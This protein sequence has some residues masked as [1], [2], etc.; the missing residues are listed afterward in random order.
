M[1]RTAHTAIVLTCALA[2]TTLAACAKHEAQ[3]AAEAVEARSVE[4][5]QGGEAAPAEPRSP[6]GDL[7]TRMVIREATVDLR[8]DHPGDVADSIINL[9]A[10]A[11]GF[12]VQ[13]DKTGVGDEVTRVEVTLRVPE[14]EFEPTLVRLRALG[15]PLR[16]QI[17]GQDVT[18]EFVDLQARLR[19]K[20]KLETRLTEILGQAASVKETLEVEN[21]LARVR[22][23]IE[24]LQGRSKYLEDRVRMSTIH[25][26]ATAPFQPTAVD[27]ESFASHMAE[28][29]D[30]AGDAFVAVVGGLVVVAGA[31]APLGIVLALLG[32]A[33]MLAVRLG[34]GSARP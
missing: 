23:E 29:F 30:T 14:K 20:Q 1:N 9:A 28:A 27:P 21:E 32:L 22:T 10:S 17:G 7:Q 4:L 25:V 16:E 13:A 3:D 24:Q 12:V 2:L 8:A 6:Q 5:E 33:I 11:G 19:A 31:L 15:T 18:E 34:R 26:T